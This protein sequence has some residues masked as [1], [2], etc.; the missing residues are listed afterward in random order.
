MR[1]SPSV[2]KILKTEIESQIL[3][4]DWLRII[5]EEGLYTFEQLLYS[6]I[7]SVYDSICDHLIKVVSSSAEFIE[8]QKKLGESK[9]FKKL[10]TRPVELQLRTGTKIK[11]ESL[12]A[13]EVPKDYEGSRHLSMVFWQVNFKSSPM[14]Q[15]L[16]CLLSVICPSFEISKE[17][18]RYQGVHANFDRTRELS[19]SLGEQCIASRSTI[20]LAPEES[21]SGKRVVIAI[22][23]GRTR[24]RVYKEEEKTKGKRKQKFETPWREPKLFVI[25][26]IDEKGK[27]NKQDLPIYDSSFGDDE[28]FE[29]LEQY[30]KELEVEKAKDVQFIGDGAPWIWNRAKPMLLRLGV[31][32]SK[33]IETLDYYHAME[34]LNELMVYVEKDQKE[35]VFKKLKQ[36]LWEGDITKIKRQITK[37]ILGVD[38]DEFTPYKYFL[39]N[40]KRIDYQSFKSENRPI[41]SGVIESGIRRVINLRFKSPSTFWYPEN[42]EKLI[43]MRGIALSGRWEIMMTNLTK[44]AS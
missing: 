1:I 16:T 19:L 42:V 30:L 12:Y 43:L 8:S 20:Q 7:T 35:T 38:L 10:V 6:S 28:T 29:I 23:G 32:K 34:H 9:G 26:T 25:T 11:F 17:L 37:G 5:L 18:L 27:V 36:G 3:S 24:T 31:E 33:I 2:I 14:Y 40:R 22:D 39:K 13:K 41:G 4:E 15:S 21:L 44:K